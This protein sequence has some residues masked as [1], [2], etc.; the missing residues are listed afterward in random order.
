MA[1]I[2]RRYAT[3]IHT[4][5]S[6][7]IGL[8]LW[9]Y[10]AAHTSSLVMV[11]VQ[12]IWDAFLRNVENG[13]L[14][15]DFLSSLQGFSIGLALASVAGIAV[16]MLMASSKLIFDL[17][18]PWVSA[19]YSTPLIALAPVFIIIFGLGMTTKVAVVLSLAIFPVIINTTAGIKTTDKDLIETAQSF[20]AGRIE[21]FRKVM[22]PWSVPFILTG[23]RLAVGRALIGVV[24]AEFFGSQEGLGN[25]IFVSSQT[26]DTASVWLGVF[27]LAIIGTVL[28]RFMYTVE[29]WVAPWRQNR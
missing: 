13:R 1:S 16:G 20:G 2:Y 4:L 14:A 7:A 27:L 6:L 28:I 17:L 22:L 15:T 26:F 21:I 5:V 9:Q 11:P 12:D 10:A 24:V 23:L 8:L 25:L 18:D 19:L 29:R 3:A